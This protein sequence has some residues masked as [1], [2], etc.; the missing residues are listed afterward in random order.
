MTTF[1]RGELSAQKRAGV[2]HEAARLAPMLE[3][4]AIPRGARMFLAE[5][6]MLVLGATDRDGDPWA[7][8]LTGPP[9]FLDVDGPSTLT[10][11]ATPGPGDPLREALTEPVPVGMIVIEPDTR[12]RVR[13]NGT[14]HPTPAG[15]RVELAQV[16]GN[17]PKYIQ[18][19]VPTRTPGAPGVAWRGTELTPADLD[20][21]ATADTFFITTA[22]LDGNTDASHRGGNP[23]FLLA[24]GPTRLRWPDYAG[25]SMFNTFGNLEVNPRAGLLLPDWTTG[26]LLHLTGSAVVDWDRAHAAGVPGAQRLVDFT[27]DRVVRVDNAAGLRWSE[28]EFSRFNPQM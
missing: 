13:M 9:G 25:N 20:F 10:I 3:R 19:R 22:D 2:L 11:A 28:A 23:G 14:A 1:H 5:Q 18:A 7:T 24:S 6:P 8:L 21:I 27:V 26:T 17:C 4:P 15:L 16:Y 12:R